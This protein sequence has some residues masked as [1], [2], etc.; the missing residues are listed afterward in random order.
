MQIILLRILV[1]V[2]F[3]IKSKDLLT[4]YAATMV[5]AVINKY[6]ISKSK[7]ELRGSVALQTLR[8]NF[9]REYSHCY[10]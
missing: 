7:I 4:R 9:F 2:V 8:V 5:S 10:I 1:I 6:I 3:S